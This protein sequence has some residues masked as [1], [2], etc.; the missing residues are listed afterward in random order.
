[1][2]ELAT[3]T[4]ASPW[5]PEERERLIAE[6]SRAPQSRDLTSA[7]ARFLP[8]DLVMLCA[9]YLGA[10]PLRPGPL[11]LRRLLRDVIPTHLVLP[12]RVA[13]DVPPVIR[14]WAHWTADRADLPKRLRRRFLSAWR[15][16]DHGRAGV[17]VAL[18]PDPVGPDRLSASQDAH[19]T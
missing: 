17:R 15:H 10:D 9:D 7:V 11:L 18:V 16:D 8:Q 19:G 5:P 13:A 2:P 4:V 14:A 12:A 6:F 3:G 1:M